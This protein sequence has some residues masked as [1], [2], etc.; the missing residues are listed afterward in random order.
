VG[1]LL[2]TVGFEPDKAELGSTPSYTKLALSEC[3]EGLDI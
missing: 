2:I 1:F 3:K